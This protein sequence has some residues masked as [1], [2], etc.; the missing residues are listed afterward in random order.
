M[1]L[2]KKI[3][4]MSQKLKTNSV[5]MSKE[6]VLSDCLKESFFFKKNRSFRKN[7]RNASTL[8]E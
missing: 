3:N 6:K 7:P 4:F 1:P 8:C 5:K 2:S